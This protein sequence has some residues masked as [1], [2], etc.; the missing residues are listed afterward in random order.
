MHI[1]VFTYLDFDGTCICICIYMCVCGYV[2]M[3][4]YIYIYIYIYVNMGH[5]P[6]VFLSG[7]AMLVYAYVCSG[8]LSTQDIHTKQT[9]IICA[10]SDRVCICVYIYICICIHTCIY[11]YTRMERTWG[12][13]L[14]RRAS[15]PRPTIRAYGCYPHTHACM[16]KNACIHMY[17]YV[18]YRLRRKLPSSSDGTWTLSCRWLSVSTPTSMQQSLFLLTTTLWH[19]C[20]SAV[21]HFWTID[22]LLLCRATLLDYR[23]FSF[24]CSGSTAWCV[25]LHGAYRAEIVTAGQLEEE[26]RFRERRCPAVVDMYL[27][28]TNLVPYSQHLFHRHDPISCLFRIS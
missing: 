23:W 13:F 18:L 10:S 16:W 6:L 27:W 11:A 3:Y 14:S 7:C 26:T 20:F 4:I 24:T 2:C 15:V 22:G 8:H 25:T 21:P 5:H 17:T 1:Y 19:T 12:C 28:I 9:E